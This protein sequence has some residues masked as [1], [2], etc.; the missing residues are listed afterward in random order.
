MWIRTRHSRRKFAAKLLERV[1]D[2]YPALAELAARLD[3][4][5]VLAAAYGAVPSSSDSSS[6]SSSSSSGDSDAEDDAEDDVAVAS[7]DD[8]EDDV[9]V[10]SPDAADA[11]SGAAAS[12]EDHA[13]RR[14]R[15][16]DA[17]PIPMGHKRVR[18]AGPSA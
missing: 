15:D 9:A 1:R 14:K 16:L 2:V 18:V 7:P 6:S 17:R 11:A 10:A 4:D 8:A 3:R 5:A 12:D 13:D